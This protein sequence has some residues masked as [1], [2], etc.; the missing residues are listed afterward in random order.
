LHY[1][2]LQRCGGTHSFSL[3]HAGTDEN[4]RPALEADSAFTH[5]REED[6]GDV[7]RPVLRRTMLKAGARVLVFNRFARALEIRERHL[8]SQHLS[9]VLRHADDPEAP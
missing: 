7:C 4:A 9:G 5:Q 3:W 6:A 2:D 1:R 8:E